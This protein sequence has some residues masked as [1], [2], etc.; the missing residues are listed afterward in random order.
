MLQLEQAEL[1]EQEAADKEVTVV[2]FP[3][4]LEPLEPRSEVEAA[5]VIVLPP[6]AYLEETE[7]TEAYWFPFNGQTT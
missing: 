3:E 2:T 4:L 1:L 6:E 7:Q 5:A